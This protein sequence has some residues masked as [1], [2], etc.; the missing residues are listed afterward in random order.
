MLT[1]LSYLSRVYQM[2]GAT[3]RSTVDWARVSKQVKSQ[4]KVPSRNQKLSSGL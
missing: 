3:F 2:A 4:S 1:S